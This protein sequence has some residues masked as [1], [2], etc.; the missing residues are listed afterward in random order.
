[1]AR[2]AL[3]F[4]AARPLAVF[5]LAVLARPALRPDVLARGFAPLAAL[6]GFSRPLMAKV[7]SSIGAMPSTVFNWP[8]PA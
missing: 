1:L 6:A 2:E 3:T 5:D 4:L 8:V 7:T